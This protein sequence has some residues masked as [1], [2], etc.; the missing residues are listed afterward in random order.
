MPILYGGQLGLTRH[1][2]MKGFSPLYG[3]RTKFYGIM[4]YFYESAFTNGFTPGLQKVS[5]GVFFKPTSKLD[6]RASYHY[7]AVATDLN[8]LNRTLGHAVS[9]QGGCRFAKDISLI[10]GYTQM[11]GT[12]TMDRL[13]QGESSKRAH[14]GWF[15]LVVSPSLFTTKW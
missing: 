14:W 9:L 2:V 8:D 3:S 13:K 5:T 12:E 11:M 15:S 6:C 10:A 7:L 4:D 1:D